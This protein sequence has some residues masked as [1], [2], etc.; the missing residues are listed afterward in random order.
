M[1][2][3]DRQSTHAY[4]NERN[5]QKHQ[6]TKSATDQASAYTYRHRVILDICLSFVLFG[7]HWPDANHTTQPH[8]ATPH[9]A[10]RHSMPHHDH[11]TPHL[12]SKT[13]CAR[14]HS[15]SKQPQANHTV[16]HR[17]TTS[18]AISTQQ[19]PVVGQQRVGALLRCEGLQE[20]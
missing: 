5:T 11:A 7:R 10:T 3:T 4:V 18:V 8:H 14:T 1:Q 20:V 15:N 19:A 6:H 2:P 13:Q 12:S 17:F 9:H 16:T